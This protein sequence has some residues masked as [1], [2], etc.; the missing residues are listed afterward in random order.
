MTAHLS[1]ALKLLET[2]TDMEDGPSPIERPK[3]IQLAR[4]L[5]IITTKDPEAVDRWL[6][7]GEKQLKAEKVIG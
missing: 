4:G 2:I 1:F 7:S 6:A 3:M 5:R